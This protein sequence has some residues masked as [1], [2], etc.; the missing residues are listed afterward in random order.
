MKRVFDL[1]VLICPHCNGRRK[2]LAFITDS[3]VVRRI[4]EHLGLTPDP[5]R[6]A[7]ARSP[8]ELALPFGV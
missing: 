5:P 1:E 3:K 4:L 6:M 8:P 2:L 7:P